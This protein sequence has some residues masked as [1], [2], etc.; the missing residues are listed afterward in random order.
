MKNCEH[1]AR[2]YLGNESDL[3]C[4]CL[5]CGKIDDFLYQ[6][7]AAEQTIFLDDMKPV[8]YTDAINVRA[9]YL[10]LKKLNLNN[11]NLLYHTKNICNDN[12]KP[13]KAKVKVH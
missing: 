12:K 2:V 6:V 13:E 10:S 3:E 8:D 1:N 5:E 4:M 11:E 9:I 7:G